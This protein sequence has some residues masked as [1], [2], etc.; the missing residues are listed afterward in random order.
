MF[1]QML[2]DLVASRE[3]AWRLFVR[4]VS[5]LYRQSIL[6]YIWAF[7]PPIAT[8]L[9]FV[10][11]NAQGIIRVGDTPVPYPAYVLIGTVLWQ[12]FLDALTS[13][14]KVISSSKPMLTKVNFPREAL[15]LAAMAETIFN[16]LTRLALLIPVFVY[17]ELRVSLSLLLTPLSIV[18]LMLV[19]L[20]FGL[21]ITPIGLLYGDVG[22]AVSLFAGFWMLL[23]PVVYPPPASGVGAVLA[24]WNPVSP[25]LLTCRAWLTSQPL[26]FPIAFIAIVTAAVVVLLLAW[27]L[28]R[29]SMPILIER[30]GG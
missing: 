20:T 16:F 6:G 11:L 1:A 9:T 5:A 2:G 17:Y 7:L 23:T 30:M 22:R 8:T 19:G 10:F 24:R 18:G 26:D 4:D 14:L 15:I 12:M 21:L 29:L 27:I 25:V 3:L 28:Y 13:P